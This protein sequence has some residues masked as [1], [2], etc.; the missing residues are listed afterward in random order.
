[1]HA[2]FCAADPATDLCRIVA[3]NDDFSHG[4][5]FTGFV[6]INAALMFLQVVFPHRGSATALD[7]TLLALNGLFIGA[8]IF[9]N[10]AFDMYT[11]DE[12][13]RASIGRDI[14][15]HAP[16][17]NPVSGDYHGFE[18]YTQLIPTRMAPLTRWDFALE[19][20]MVNGNYWTTFSLLE[21]SLK[22]NAWRSDLARPAKLRR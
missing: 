2:R 8:G 3:F 22:S 15:W 10:L 16:G 21:F 12:N 20:V 13:E 17:H 19:D 9:A 1:M 11:G 6:M 5:F 7:K 14:V 18:A 4:V